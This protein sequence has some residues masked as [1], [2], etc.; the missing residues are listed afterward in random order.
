MEGHTIFYTNYFIDRATYAD[1]F[2]RRYM[3]IMDVFMV[4]LHGVIGYGKYLKLKHDANDTYG[5]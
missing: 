5:F 2:R 4:I 3:M 1:S